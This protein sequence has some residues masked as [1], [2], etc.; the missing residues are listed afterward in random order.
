MIHRFRFER[1]ISAVIQRAFVDFC[2]GFEVFLNESEWQAAF[3]A[4]D[5]GGAR[6][7]DNFGKQVLGAMAPR[8]FV[9][10]YLGFKL[11]LD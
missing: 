8:A 5:K 6:S 9:D 7:F 2:R 10:F 11:S 3:L 1:H 4:V